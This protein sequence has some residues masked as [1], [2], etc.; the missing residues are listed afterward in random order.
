M[1]KK[2]KV[3]GRLSFLHYEESERGGEKRQG[4]VAVDETEM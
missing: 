1:Q 3:A 2:T 4:A